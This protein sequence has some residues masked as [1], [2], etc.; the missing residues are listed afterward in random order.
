MLK[1]RKNSIIP[2][3]TNTSHNSTCPD[4]PQKAFFLKEGEAEK[5]LI[6]CLSASCS[7]YMSSQ[8]RPSSSKNQFQISRSLELCESVLC[9]FLIKQI[10]EQVSM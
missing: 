7:P 3:S 5:E 10:T 9:K 1:L 2:R 4:L 8:V 6:Y